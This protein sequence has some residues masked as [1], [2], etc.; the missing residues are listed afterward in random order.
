MD[1]KK[2]AWKTMKEYQFQDVNLL[3]DLYEKMKPWIDNHPNINVGID[4]GD[5]CIACGSDSVQRNGVRMTR[6]GQYVRYRCANCGK[7]MRGKSLIQSS[8]LRN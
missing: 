1:G 8:N 2:S 5:K 6:V 3:I 7:N 4:D